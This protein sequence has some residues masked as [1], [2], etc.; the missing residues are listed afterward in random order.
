[1]ST[2]FDLVITDGQ[3][4]TSQGIFPGTLVVRDGRISGILEPQAHP[5]GQHHISAKGLHILPGLIDSHVHL[6]SPGN[7]EREDP[8]T[9]TSAAAV[10]AGV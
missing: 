7:A 3:I 2:S 8:V 5:D 1:M 4:V 10:L 9:G 6:R